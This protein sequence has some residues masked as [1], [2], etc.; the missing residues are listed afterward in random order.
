MM[1][2]MSQNF[3]KLALFMGTSNLHGKWTSRLARHSEGCMRQL[4]LMM[5]GNKTCQ[6]QTSIMSYRL[7]PPD[8]N[9]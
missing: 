6:N 5:R 9:C 7:L 4:H 3:K 2:I 8:F 1:G